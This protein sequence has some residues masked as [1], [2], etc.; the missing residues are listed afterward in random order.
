MWNRKKGSMINWICACQ[1]VVR[2]M[3][4][5]I[6]T[7]VIAVKLVKQLFLK[8]VSGLLLAQS[9]VAAILV[10][11]GIYTLT[12]RLQ[13]SFKDKVLIMLTFSQ[14]YKCIV[15]KK[16]LQNILRQCNFI[17]RLEDCY[18]KNP[19]AE[20]YNVKLFKQTTTN[21]NY[22]QIMVSFMYFLKEIWKKPG[23]CL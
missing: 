4:M 10:F 3:Y 6:W 8:E 18:D 14:Y 1:S 5:S 23:K 11:S 17:S 19:T 13:V 2:Y 22:Y 16:V 15:G 9:Y 20:K 12:K 21:F 7:V